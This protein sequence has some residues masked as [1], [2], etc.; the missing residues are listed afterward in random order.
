MKARLDRD[1]GDWSLQTYL[2][3]DGNYI[4]G[5]VG[6]Q[7]ERLN[8][9]K[10][11]PA[12][13]DTCSYVYH[14]HVGHGR[15]TIVTAAGETRTVEWETNDTFAVPAW[16]SITHYNDGDEDAYLFVLSDRPLMEA[17]KLYHAAEM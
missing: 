1:S 2:D 9:K 15:S 11:S 4:S 7:A 14:A 6:A 3:A 13:K 10:Q 17:L 5:T 16:S 8:A 12:R